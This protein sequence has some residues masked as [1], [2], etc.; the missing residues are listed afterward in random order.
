M[1]KNSMSPEL[2]FENPSLPEGV[3][4]TDIGLPVGFYNVA[5]TDVGEGKTALEGRYVPSVD[6]E[7]QPDTPDTG[8]TRLIV[9][10]EH[11]IVSGPKT[12]WTPEPTST[13]TLL[14]RLT[15]GRFG[16]PPQK[17]DE[18]E[19]IRSL[20]TDIWATNAEEG[21]DPADELVLQCLTRVAYVAGKPIP[22]PAIAW[23]TK[24]QL[25]AGQFPDTNFLQ[26]RDVPYPSLEPVQLGDA[27]V[28]PG[29]NA[30]GIW[31][32]NNGNFDVGFRPEGWNHDFLVG[33][34]GLASDGI[35]TNIRR[36]G[37]AEKDRRRWLRF[38]AGFCSPPIPLNEW[39]SFALLHGIEDRKPNDPYTPDD[40]Y[41]YRGGTARITRNSRGEYAID[42]ISREPLLVPEHL[43]DRV[44][45]HPDI[46]EVVYMDGAITR[47]TNNSPYP[48]IEA[49]PQFG[50]TKTMRLT[51]SSLAVKNTV[52]E[53]E[54]TPVD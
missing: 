22:F 25:L 9:V 27:L 39:E 8:E 15:G 12:L 36:L 6:H 42:N 33:E 10:N 37:I 52:G 17:G 34:V 19:D 38:K 21:R 35:V 13:P 43:P 3:E 24:R 7:G 32:L 54:R 11:G 23:T 18:I 46:R 4:L 53:W 28:V 1:I 16:R 50:D 14:R 20:D 47:Y 5:A 51:I 2:P 31:A 26:F 41:K 40:L 30:M 49:Y 48:G 29:K 44:E 45:L